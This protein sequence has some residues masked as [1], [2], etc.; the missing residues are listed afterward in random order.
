MDS[1]R[2]ADIERSRRIIA[3]P[4]ARRAL[5][6]RGIDGATLRGS[7]PGGRIVAADVPL[8]APTA[9]SATQCTS[10]MRRA[11]ARR[12]SESWATIPHIVLHAQ[13]D[14]SALVALRAEVVQDIERRHGVR[15]TITDFLLRAMM[16]SLGEHPRANRVWRGD[17]LVALDAPAIGLV[18]GLDDGLAIPVIGAG[19]D[20]SVVARARD[21]AVTRVRS[22]GA[23]A[24]Q[25]CASSLSNL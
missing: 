2:T 17:E 5:R 1:A 11:I 14:A 19:A 15:P 20:L 18:V 25:P 24:S 9:R 3:S 21:L 22:G 7:G 23:A 16:I 4:R 13:A 12:T 6:Q 8:A 10:S